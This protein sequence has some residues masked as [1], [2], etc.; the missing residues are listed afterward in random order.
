MSLYLTTRYLACLIAIGSLLVSCDKVQKTTKDEKNMTITNE[1][2]ITTPSGLKYVEKHVG[3]GV[4]AEKGKTISV[5]YV[6]TLED[7]TKFDSSLDRGQPIDFKLGVGQV[8]KGW[9]EGLDGVKVGGKRKL[10]IP[11]EL[12]YGSRAAGKIPANST[13]IFEVELVGVK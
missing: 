10:I 12:G 4:I 1:E 7:G 2:I 3:N 11:A 6:G 8:I 13:L 5:H 9:D